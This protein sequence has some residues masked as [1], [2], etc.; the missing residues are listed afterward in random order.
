MKVRMTAPAIMLAALFVA[1]TVVAAGCAKRTGIQ[2]A[3][4][5]TSSMQAVESN[6]RQTVA[7][8]DATNAALAAVLDAKDSPDV[9]KTYDAYADNVNKMEK[10]GSALLKQ[11]NEMTAQG[12]DYFEEW[13][14]S[15][16]TYTN[17]DIQKLS[18][19]RRNQLQQTFSEI[20][21]ASPGVNG[22]LNAYLSDIKQIQTY[23]SN[24]LTPQG[25]AAISPVARD[26]IQKGDS[27]KSAVQP[28]L[29]ATARARS[30]MSEG[31]AAGGSAGQST[32]GSEGYQQN[33]QDQQNMFR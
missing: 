3:E 9:K 19:E 11:T 28:M 20:S 14:K 5:T 15:G 2:R 18:Q 22:S 27:V 29:A 25:I 17:P 32:G 10:S 8:I 26:T 16:S 13:Q 12:N 7:Q 6:I 4:K 21:Q 30:E 31:A 33:Q 24:D 1:I 23:L